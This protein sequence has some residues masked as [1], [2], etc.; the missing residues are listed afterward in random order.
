MTSTDNTPQIVIRPAHSD[1]RSAL[2]RLAAL[3]SSV[4]PTGRVLVAE[5]DGELVAAMPVD[6]GP[7]IADPFRATAAMVA[8]LE[9]RA[10]Q[11]EPAGRPEHRR[12]ALR[13]RR[14][15]AHAA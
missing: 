7:A 4:V 6:G 11:I 12:F 14:A 3:D 9:L 5:I 2:V 15:L 10:G 13:P 8:L 1:D